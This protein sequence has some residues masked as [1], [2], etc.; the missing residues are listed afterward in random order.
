MVMAVPARTGSV[1]GVRRFPAPRRAP[2]WEEVRAAMI[3]DA[4]EVV[5]AVRAMCRVPADSRV[6]D[7]VDRAIAAL[8]ERGA[9]A[10][11]LVFD[12]LVVEMER[13]AAVREFLA[14]VPCR[15]RGLRPVP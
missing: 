1:P 10:G 11:C 3:A 7:R 4:A 12:D 14:A 15:C 2:V 5:A 8:N 9:Q 6:H 13:A